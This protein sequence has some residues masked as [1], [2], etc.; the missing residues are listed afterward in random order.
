MAKY[1]VKGIFSCAIEGASERYGPELRTLDQWRT[2]F[3]FVNAS[4][5]PRNLVEAVLGSLVETELFDNGGISGQIFGEL[6]SK[7]VESAI[8]VIE[9][10]FLE[11]LSVGEPGD[12]SRAVVARLLSGLL[13]DWSGYDTDEGLDIFNAYRVPLQGLAG[14]ILV[15]GDSL[16]DTVTEEDFLKGVN[17]YTNRSDDL[18]NLEGLELE[19]ARFAYANRAFIS[20]SVLAHYKRV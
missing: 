16:E 6:L 5:L 19:A 11:E 1:D 13:R 18:K 3:V 4:I 15:A 10:E 14:L 12:N 7:K 2:E 8:K 20:E 9:H 17:W